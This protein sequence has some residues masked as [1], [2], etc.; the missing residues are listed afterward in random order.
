MPRRTAAIHSLLAVCTALVAV[1]CGKEE[2]PRAIVRGNVT[3]NGAPLTEGAVTFIPASGGIGRSPIAPD[4][5]YSLI[6]QDK[7]EGVAPGNYTVI[8]MPSMAQI[9]KA[10]VDPLVSVKTSEIPSAYNNLTT[11]PLKYAVEVGPNMIDL[12]LEKTPPKPK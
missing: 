5:S 4:G 7:K 3:L 6:G 9:K 8:V 12:V 11:S 1:G 2:A 10:Q